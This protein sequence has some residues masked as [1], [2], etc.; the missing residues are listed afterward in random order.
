VWGAFTTRS[1][2]VRPEGLDA[3]VVAK[4]LGMANAAAIGRDAVG[5]LNKRVLVISHQASKSRQPRSSTASMMRS[6]LFHQTRGGMLLMAC[7][8]G[9]VISQSTEIR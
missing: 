5:W 1:P 3:A 7:H 4:P 9:R 8:M 2:L 6:R